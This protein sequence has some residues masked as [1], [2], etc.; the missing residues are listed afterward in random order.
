MVY[1]I[2]VFT[3]RHPFH[4]RELAAFLEL[5]PVPLVRVLRE[6]HPFHGRELAAFLKRTTVLLVRFLRESIESLR[7]LR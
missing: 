1:Q 7:F 6:R 4:G 2:Y 3:V 5:T